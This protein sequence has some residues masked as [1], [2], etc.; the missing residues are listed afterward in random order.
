MCLVSDTRTGWL[1]VHA[2]GATLQ[3]GS[4]SLAL[5]SASMSSLLVVGMLGDE[6]GLRNRL[7]SADRTPYSCVCVED[8]TKY[9]F[10][11]NAV[12]LM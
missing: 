2:H 12:L 6:S 1:E 9:G 11:T 10:T 5:L 4:L 8:G 3:V 7:R